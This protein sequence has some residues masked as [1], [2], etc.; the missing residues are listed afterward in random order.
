LAF[1]VGP[2]EPATNII[3]ILADEIND[4]SLLNS[5]RPEARVRIGAADSAGEQ[6]RERSFAVAGLCRQGVDEAPLQHA[7]DE[8][9]RRNEVGEKVRLT[10]YREGARWRGCGL[11]LVELGPHR[12]DL[13]AQAPAILGSDA[14]GIALEQRDNAVDGVSEVLEHNHYVPEARAA[15]ARVPALYFK[16]RVG[17]DGG[18]VGRFGRAV[19]L[20]AA[21]GAL[22]PCGLW[23][24]RRE[25]LVKALLRPPPPG[26]EAARA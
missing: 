12:L 16:Q 20:P 9:I 15:F 19:G 3:R 25:F 2:N 17:G 26:N 18:F 13:M 4:P 7:I 22:C 8:I 21:V 5:V 6:K 23:V 14:I 10:L 24:W 11:A 1:G